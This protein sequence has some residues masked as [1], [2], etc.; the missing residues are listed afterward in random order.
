[1]LCTTLHISLPL[2][3]W[4]GAFPIYQA[5][6]YQI[7]VLAGTVQNLGDGSFVGALTFD[8]LNSPHIQEAFSAEKLGTKSV[9]CFKQ[10]N[11]KQF[12][13]KDT[14]GAQNRIQKKDNNFL[15]HKQISVNGK[16]LWAQHVVKETI[17]PKTPPLDF[18][19][20]KGFLHI[21]KT[22]MKLLFASKEKPLPQ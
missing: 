11:T 19:F 3:Q 15:V 21:L 10:N 13:F 1:D 14:F 18:D 7:D 9:Q 12:F 16:E 17:F 22:L 8:I 2:D 5:G 6:D 4:K 20:S